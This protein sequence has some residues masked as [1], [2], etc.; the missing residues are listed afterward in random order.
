MTFNIIIFSAIFGIFFPFFSVKA[1]NQTAIDI[2]IDT[3]SKSPEYADRIAQLNLTKLVKEFSILD[4]N[5]SEDGKRNFTELANAYG[6]QSE[7]YNVT[8]EDGYILTLFHIP[9][10]GR[11]Y[12]LMHGLAANAD[13]FALRKNNSLAFTLADKGYDVWIGNTR[14]NDYSFGHVKYDAKVDEEYWD[15]SLHENGYYDYPAIIDFILNKTSQEKLTLIGH[16]QGTIN[17]FVLGSLR[18]EYNDKINIFIAL[19]PVAVFKPRGILKPFLKVVPAD[20]LYSL[21][22]ASGFDVIQINTNN[23]NRNFIEVLCTQKVLSYEICWQIIIFSMIGNDAESFEPE[24]S[25]VLF[26]HV[27]QKSSNKNLCHIAQLSKRNKFA[28]FDYGT[29]KNLVK[30]GAL[31]P[32]KYD[33]SKVTMKVALFVGFNDY[34]ASIEGAD[35]LNAEL[36]NVV[37]YTILPRPE[38]NHFDFILGNQ[39]QDNFYPFLFDTLEEYP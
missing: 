37:E 34:V 12:L 29:V 39:V 38:F 6:H 10:T 16:S 14:G 20:T 21:S 7:E 33:L 36:P 15:F 5:L 35:I 1:A 17:G 26:G 3:L 4:S 11:P 32:P 28:Q 23:V 13:C 2:F 18:P 19:A 9:G 24:F 27:P 22:K 31:N 25:S 8:T 30:Y